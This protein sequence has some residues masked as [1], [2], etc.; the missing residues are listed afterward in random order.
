M[1]INK[2]LGI[3][4]VEDDEGHALLMEEALRAS[5]SIQKVYRVKDGEECLLFVHREKPVPDLIL[6]DIK[7]PKLDGYGVLHQLK[8]NE[9]YRSIPVIIVSSMSNPAEID[10]C[11]RLGVTAYIIKPISYEELRQKMEGL[12]KFLSVVALPRTGGR[13]HENSSL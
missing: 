1:A 2:Q 10:Y 12:G 7:L 6:L 11:Y 4:L 5:L 13:D 8:E 3:L 9:K